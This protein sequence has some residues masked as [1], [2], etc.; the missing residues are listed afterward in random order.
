LQS[1]SG[2]TKLQFRIEGEIDQGR[3]AHGRESFICLLVRRLRKHAKA[4]VQ[5]LSERHTANPSLSQ[6]LA[7]ALALA[8]P[9]AA[10]QVG[11]IG[12]DWTGNDIVI[13]AIA[14]PKVK[15]I[16]CH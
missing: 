9:A 12:T 5:I 6:Y 14:D 10:E 16:T 4:H 8:T 2:D 13:E 3:N 15:G 7:A 11:E 1:A